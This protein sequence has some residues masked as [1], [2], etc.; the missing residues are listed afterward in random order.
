MRRI[1]RMEKRRNLEE[2]IM[3]VAAD[4]EQPFPAPHFDEEKFKELE[5]KAEKE[6]ST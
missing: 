6:A 4:D 5:K 3:E 1:M 2:V